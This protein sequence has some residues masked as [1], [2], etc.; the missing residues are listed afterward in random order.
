MIICLA[1]DYDYYAVSHTNEAAA[2]RAS[3]RLQSKHFL[4]AF[5]AQETSQKKKGKGEREGRREKILYLA[6]LAGRRHQQLS[7]SFKTEAIIAI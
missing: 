1:F 2:W 3:V 4:G 7:H 5:V 6:T